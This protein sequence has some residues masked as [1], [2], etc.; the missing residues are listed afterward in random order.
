MKMTNSLSIDSSFPS[1]VRSPIWKR[2]KEKKVNFKRL[3][4]TTITN[5]IT[6]TITTTT[7]TTTTTTHTSIGAHFPLPLIVNY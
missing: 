6:T 1:Q 3:Y 7:T 2:E 5:T 4:I